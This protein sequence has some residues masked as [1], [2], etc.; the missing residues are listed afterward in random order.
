M[1]GRDILAAGKQVAESVEVSGIVREWNSLEYSPVLTVPA[2][3]RRTGWGLRMKRNGKLGVAGQWGQ[4]DPYQLVERGIGSC[5]YGPPANFDLP[6]EAPLTQESVPDGLAAMDHQGA[7]DY[8]EE[9]RQGMLKRV[10]NASLSGRIFWSRDSF[11]LMNTRGLNAGYGKTRA[12]TSL[13]ATVPTSE[14]LM[15]SGCAMDTSCSLPSVNDA[16][17]SL[18]LPL[19]FTG[20]TPGE[21]VGRKRVVLAPAAFSILL[22]GIRAGVSG[23][24]LSM[25]SSPLQGLE[26]D[27]VLSDKLTLRDL[28]GLANGAASA[29]FDSEG[30]PASDKY[31]FRDGVFTGFIHD[32]QTAAASGAAEST[33][34][35]GRNLG[36]HSR[37]VCTNLVVTPSHGTTDWTLEETG[38]G[39]LVTGILSAGGGDAA[40]GRFTF[41]CG[42]VF[43]FRRG[44]IQ[45]YFDGCVISGNVYD[46]L[47]RI[48]AVGG[49]GYRT[50]SDI[51]PFVSL[52]GISV[53]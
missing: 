24:L 22:Q 25:G 53:R 38:S 30:I 46:A 42:R 49:R 10:P 29:P 5:R 32:L 8:L 45:G 33:G 7:S 40:S 48:I 28:P 43:L 37:P 52:D 13:S 16:V 4:V 12:V 6:S 3:G 31:L 18:S 26:G 41:D 47:S 15:Q 27:K 23:R 21:A 50:G 44:E 9:V 35:S 51:L 1:D 19:A 20:L 39:I 34:N 2:S 14:G 36:E 17:E 11:T